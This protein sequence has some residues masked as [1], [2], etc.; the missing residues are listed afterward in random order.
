[1]HFQEKK[2]GLKSCFFGAETIPMNVSVVK[3]INVIKCEKL[4]QNMM[5]FHAHSTNGTFL[6]FRTHF[7]LVSFRN[8]N[9]IERKKNAFFEYKRVVA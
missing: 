3:K 1:M 6:L 5:L 7:R 2:T 8:T 9:S 4:Q